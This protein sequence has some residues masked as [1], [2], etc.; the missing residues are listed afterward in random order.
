[1]AEQG[2]TPSVFKT[3][4]QTE[5]ALESR[6]KALLG[7]NSLGSG[8]I[9][10]EVDVPGGSVRKISSN[11]RV[12]RVRELTGL[13]ER[14]LRTSA[15]SNL[16][17][18]VQRN[19]ELNNL[20][21]EK[22]KK[23]FL[24][25]AKK[26]PVFNFGASL[27]GDDLAYDVSKVLYAGASYGASTL[28]QIGLVVD[29]KV[30]DVRNAIGLGSNDSIIE[31]AGGTFTREDLR[32]GNRQN[33]S[34][35]WIKFL[36]RE[37]GITNSLDL[38]A[39]IVKELVSEPFTITT[40]LL[41]PPSYLGL[42]KIKKDTLESLVGEEGSEYLF[43]EG[44]IGYDQG[45]DT[46]NFIAEE[47]VEADTLN[48]VFIGLGIIPGTG[49]IRKGFR[50]GRKGAGLIVAPKLLP[51][52]WGSTQIN[53]NSFEK[54]RRNETLDEIAKTTDADA[55]HAILRGSDLGSIDEASYNYTLR[56]LADDLAGIAD[57]DEVALLINRVI[58][59][60]ISTRTANE[61]DA[62]DLFR[63]SISNYLSRSGIQP[64]MFL[65]VVPVL[66]RIKDGNIS[67]RVLNKLKVHPS[68]YPIIQY[69]DNFD[70]VSRAI[71]DFEQLGEKTIRDVFTDALSTPRSTLRN[72]YIK[73]DEI[74]SRLALAQ[75][76]ARLY[77]G[78]DSLAIIR[79]RYA[80]ELKAAATPDERTA[81]EN[82]I[83]KRNTKRLN[84]ANAEVAQL[85]QSLNNINDLINRELQGLSR[86]TA[87]NT[88]L[89]EMIRV[90]N[91]TYDVK[92]G[93][94]KN[95][96]PS[97]YSFE[98]FLKNMEEILANAKKLQAEE[99]LDPLD[100]L[101]TPLGIGRSTLLEGAPSV[102]PKTADAFLNTVINPV[103]TKI[104][105]RALNKSAKVPNNIAWGLYERA[106]VRLASMVREEA[107]PLYNFNRKVKEVANWKE[108]PDKYN[109]LLPIIRKFAYLTE[110]GE[111]M[112]RYLD[113]V[114]TQAADIAERTGFAP[115]Q[116]I[117]DFENYI[118][119]VRSI[120]YNAALKS[121]N[122][123]S[124]VLKEMKD[125]MDYGI[126]DETF[127]KVAQGAYDTPTA[128]KI[129]DEMRGKYDNSDLTS[130]S[131][132]WYHF[133]D[134]TL[135]MMVNGGV[136]SERLALRLRT[137]S[138]SYVNLRRVM[139]GE[140]ASAI[141]GVRRAKGSVKEVISPIVS[142]F[143]YRA[144]AMRYLPENIVRD[145][146]QNVLTIKGVE[147][148]GYLERVKSF[149]T[150]SRS[151]E[152]NKYKAKKDHL[153][154]QEGGNIVF[155]KITDKRFEAAYNAFRRQVTP[156]GF[157][158]M[159]GQITRHMTSG[160]TAYN[161]SFTL[162]NA[163][164]DTMAIFSTIASVY[165]PRGF[166]EYIPFLFRSILRGFSPTGSAQWTEAI[167]PGRIF[168][169]RQL[170]ER[171]IGGSGQVQE[172]LLAATNPVQE[173]FKKGSRTIQLQ[174]ERRVKVPFTKKE[175][176][177]TGT[178]ITQGLDSRGRKALSKLGVKNRKKQDVVI[179]GAQ[180]L[181]IWKDIKKLANNAENINRFASFEYAL[182]KGGTAE[183]AGFAAQRFPIDFRA[184]G[185]GTRGLQQL[186]E[187]LNIPGTSK[188]K[189]ALNR[190]WGRTFAFMNAT[191]QAASL[192]GSVATT[193]PG[194]STMV[195]MGYGL[196]ELE[197][198]FMGALSDD[199][200]KELTGWLE[201]S[202]PQIYNRNLIIPLGEGSL[203]FLKV[204]I[205]HEGTAFL[206]FG[207]RLA[208]ARNGDITFAEA[209]EGSLN[210]VWGDIW[211]NINYFDE[212]VGTGVNILPTAARPY[213][214]VVGNKAWYGS[215]IRPAGLNS[216]SLLEDTEYR[217]EREQTDTERWFA[218]K[219][220]EIFSDIPIVGGIANSLGLTESPSDTKYLIDGYFAGFA[221]IGFGAIDTV[222]L[223]AGDELVP[224]RRRL[225][226]VPEVATGGVLGGITR[227]FYS[228]G[229]TE[230][231]I[232]WSD[233]NRHYEEMYKPT[234]DKL[235]RKDPFDKIDI[236]IQIKLDM[237]ANDFSDVD[238]ERM[239]NIIK[240]KAIT[241]SSN[242]EK[243]N[244]VRML[245]T[246]KVS[247]PKIRYH[248]GRFFPP[249]EREFYL[250]YRVKFGY[251]PFDAANI[252]KRVYENYKQRANNANAYYGLDG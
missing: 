49:L 90:G 94:L 194:L 86:T 250:Y 225:K 20:R 221:D 219:F 38:S 234:L 167:T 17:S 78:S 243:Y 193:V 80:K 205:S 29:D 139:P 69:G 145:R 35:F 21:E 150:N 28:W 52:K 31:E 198:Y 114:L 79:E 223:L 230:A 229:P 46:I 11:P 2:L 166:V 53:L 106:T 39:E 238:Q 121:R 226:N 76:T 172:E 138:N 244:L 55:I 241:E 26:D 204:P 209:M 248:N 119:A 8:T 61:A 239:I 115:Q 160:F 18:E 196:A 40:S 64:S 206:N 228:H 180:W 195:L 126:S 235:D 144:L 24:Q 9:T 157:T 14:V 74:V 83:R 63:R 173:Q 59:R 231:Q 50:L 123:D 155:Y 104:Y 95:P 146:L 7:D 186:L 213:F 240:D 200:R 185:S 60:K 197:R 37:Q 43:N 44:I 108:L 199:Q 70:E 15:E 81:L 89:N 245:E 3:Q 134:E 73:Q 127:G 181:N 133:N 169:K 191:T 190:N 97:L 67:T 27:L 16:I 149:S 247:T 179:S 161:P 203:A 165:G 23:L 41:T 85:Q 25:E 232:E 182:W 72:I 130:F 233:L 48:K 19:V 208:A 142:A 249:G 140:E 227:S 163:A 91:S 132:R 251:N 22:R 82:Q 201:Q 117:K 153:W 189:H 141:Y 125:S 65:P 5:R 62:A 88:F 51:F 188:S 220:Y 168:T 75:K 98:T 92:T 101:G 152:L 224:A 217:W 147:E 10:R 56:G 236:M 4:T 113:D 71:K 237:L 87:K 137:L 178:P 45:D 202:R 96:D 6:R 33:L 110:Q 66:D 162:K 34:E 159:L 212:G 187:D 151:K 77:T 124:E 47:F 215:P 158:T 84:K 218:R 111:I 154:T 99:I 93:L 32:Q 1:M 30:N 207:R 222:R 12:E 211:S 164:R 174:A 184:R 192:F 156:D 131:E 128:R 170:E 120:E 105:N 175:W 210:N 58:G 177:W 116:V 136:V 100:D 112:V 176:S 252:A 118:K 68:L 171:G 143:A 13:S 102:V 36:I 103:L 107:F 57:R 216:H 129:I 54:L 42:P 183:Q 135:S 246:A 148:L 122:V 242:F 109:V 214:D